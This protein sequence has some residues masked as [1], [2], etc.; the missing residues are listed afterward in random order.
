MNKTNTPQDALYKATGLTIQ[1][2]IDKAIGCE[3][4]FNGIGG[5][6]IDEKMAIGYQ[7]PLMVSKILLDPKA[8]QAV[9]KT[10]GWCQESEACISCDLGRTTNAKKN[11]HRMIDYLCED[12]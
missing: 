7:H 8:W 1:E 3:W 9:G 6:Y 4:K 10:E 5:T 2:F 11:M 12:I